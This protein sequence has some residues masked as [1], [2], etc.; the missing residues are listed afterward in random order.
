MKIPKKY[1]QFENQETLI[2]ICGR[3]KAKVLL[4]KDGLLEKLEDFGI[5]TPQYSDR[6]G[7]F[8]TRIKD[9]GV[10]K[11]GAVYEDKKEKVKKELLKELKKRLKKV[12]FDKKTPVIN[13]FSPD[14]LK[15]EAEEAVKQ[16]FHKSKPSYYSGNFYSQ[17]NFAV[18]EVLKKGYSPKKEVKKKEAKKILDKTKAARKIIKGK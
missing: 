2:I 11:S 5:E 3:Q 4:A 8:K 13:L 16:V 1:P 15:N 17:S 14:Y 6:E 12:S 10:A 7:F 18:L 9:V